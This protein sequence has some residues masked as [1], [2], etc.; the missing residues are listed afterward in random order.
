MRAFWPG[1]VATSVPVFEIQLGVGAAV[2]PVRQISSDAGVTSVLVFAKNQPV[3]SP[4]TKVSKILIDFSFIHRKLKIFLSFQIIGTS[5]L[6]L[7][8]HCK[9]LTTFL[10]FSWFLGVLMVFVIFF[11]F[12]YI[13][14]NF[15]KNGELTKIYEL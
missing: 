3:Q 12:N 5:F 8:A 10:N 7:P 9:F 13:K 11:K 4:G 14:T 6:D 2:V 15:G 1:A